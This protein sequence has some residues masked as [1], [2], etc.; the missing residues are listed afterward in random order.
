MVATKIQVR[1]NQEIAEYLLRVNRNKIAPVKSLE[2]E[3]AMHMQLSAPCDC[4]TICQ[5]IPDPGS[6]ETRPTIDRSPSAR[7]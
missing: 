5:V 3:P 7:K 1:R 2:T 4:E 6:E